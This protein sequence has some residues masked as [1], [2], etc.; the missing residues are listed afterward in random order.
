MLL[1]AG[2]AESAK[3]QDSALDGN[4]QNT[5]VLMRGQQDVVAAKLVTWLYVTETR[6]PVHAP[7]LMVF[8]RENAHWPRMHAFREKIEENIAATVKPGEIIAWFDQYPPG[9]ADGIRAYANALLSQGYV[10]RAQKALRQF[11]T[12]ASL[13]R[14]ETS[15]IAGAYKKHLSADDHYARLDNLIWKGRY[16]EAEYMLAFVPSDRRALAHA[17]ISLGQLSSKASAFL[18]M[19]P[20]TLRKD[21]GLLFERLRYRRRKNMNE[22]ALEILAMMPPAPAKPEMWWEEIKILARRR[23]EERDYAG[24]YALA[25]N[26]TATSGVAFAEAEWLLG[27]LS[28][29]HLK[30]TADAYRHFDG[31][32]RSVGSAISK[33]RAAY[34]AA[35]AAE[36]LPDHVLA[37]EWD[38]IAALY[39]STYYGQLSYARVHK[40]PDAQM[41]AEA[42]VAPETLARFESG[43]IVRAARLLHKTG[44][45]QFIDP[46]LA[47]LLADA[48]SGQDYYLAAK[49]AHE[50]G[51][52]YYAVEA[53]KEAQQTLGIF[54]LN[55]G[56]PV[57]PLLPVAEPEK[58]LIHAIIHRESMFDRNAQSPAGARG[59]MQL[60]PATAKAMSKK[61]GKTYRLQKLTEDPQFNITLGAAYLQ[62]MVSLY[63]GFYPMAIAA[64]NAGPGRVSQWIREF[65]DPRKGEIDVIDWVEHIPIYETRNYVQRVL[66]SYYIYR[67]RFGLPPRTIEDLTR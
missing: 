62:Q 31:L 47:K 30:D 17:R 63:D 18:L 60:M 13:G 51:R 19:V 4:W 3:K 16:S 23:I 8:V 48:K 43:E 25:K 21:E 26:H 49:L 61:K 6:I 66:E 11:W 38:K 53:N 9:K 10:D 64:Y 22:G 14:N 52:P 2:N 54:L 36:A 33:S 37:A 59:L 28:L 44:L 40:T 35:R 58:S 1:A 42:P 39:P 34:W 32:Y 29:R 67:L 27:W 55:E 41:L 5:F 24:A 15:S 20:E 7:D 50:T 46:F 65:G 45:A 56:Y 57:I 12:D